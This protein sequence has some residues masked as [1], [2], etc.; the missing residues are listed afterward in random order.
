MAVTARLEQIRDLQPNAVAYLRRHGFVM[1]KVGPLAEDATELDRW[2]V[3]AFSLYTD[4]VEA[5]TVAESLLAEH[6]HEWQPAGVMPVGNASGSVY[7]WAMCGCGEIEP[8][9]WDF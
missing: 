3:L 6:V 1:D 4:L 2:K 9:Q 7:I 8:H 5:S